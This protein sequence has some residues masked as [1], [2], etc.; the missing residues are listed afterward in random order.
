MS[1]DKESLRKDLDI[2]TATF[3]YNTYNL[4]ETL[5]GNLKDKKSMLKRLG[6]AAALVGGT[7]V[8]G[9]REAIFKQPRPAKAAEMLSYR[10]KVT[11][12]WGPEVSKIIFNGLP[13]GTKWEY[14]EDGDPILTDTIKFDYEEFPIRTSEDFPETGVNIFEDDGITYVDL[15]TNGVDRKYLPGVFKNF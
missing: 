5:K 11:L 12:E 13:K 7:A 4:L 10:D 2:D 15:G 3:T 14:L 6:I 9:G 1:T 8:V